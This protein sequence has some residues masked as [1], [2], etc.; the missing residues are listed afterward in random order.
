MRDL[1]VKE[2]DTSSK[3][4]IEIYNVSKK[5]SL[6]GSKKEILALK[7]VNLKIKKGE[8]FGLLGPNGAGKTTLISILATLLRPSS[9]FA[10]V[11]GYNVLKESWAVKENI[12]LMFGSEM[13]YHR[14]TGY[15]NLKFFCKL[16]GIKDFKKKISNIAEELELTN[17]LDQY[18]SFYSSGMKLKLALAR[19]LLLDPKIL[20]LDEP[21]IGL[22]P[23][24]VN[25][26]VK[27][28]LNLK[29]TIFLTSH[30]MNVVQ[31]LCDRIAFLKKGT[32]LK[33]D[34]Q[35]NFRKLIAERI[36]I[37]VEISNQRD[38]LINTLKT[39]DFVDQIEKTSK[40]ITFFIKNE[41]DFPKLFNS[42]KNYP[43]TSF[44][45]LKPN[46]EDIF[47]RLGD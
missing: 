24:S 16:Y 26:T 11:C 2:E 41:T 44:N 20:F 47:I 17:W 25:W 15:R 22:D 35:E 31:K 30:Q 27:F 3:Y 5:Y 39:L 19:V 10:K 1:K 45:Q 46:L 43:I 9:G 18:V 21:T 40:N 7:N 29:K 8:I 42:L 13:I 34:T 23:K 6:K 36:R 38:I 12:G 14:L 28:L 4:D 32:I 33:V 37:E